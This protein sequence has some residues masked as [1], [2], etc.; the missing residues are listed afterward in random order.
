M[1]MIMT[2]T[3]ILEGFLYSDGFDDLVAM[4][5]KLSLD[6]TFDTLE[7]LSEMKEF[8]PYQL[9][10]YVETLR[11]GRALIVVL[12]WFTSDDWLDATIQMNKYSLRLESEF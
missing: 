6:C 10:D 4:R 1:R 12:E 7:R 2:P 11:Y 9:E 3:E 5:L 8:N